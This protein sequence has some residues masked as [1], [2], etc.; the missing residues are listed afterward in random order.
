MRIPNVNVDFEGIKVACVGDSLTYGTTLLNRKVESYP[1]RL[2]KLLGKDYDVLNLGLPGYALNRQS[3]KCIFCSPV[4][5]VLEK[6]SPKYVVALIG[7]NDARLKNYTS[8]KDFENYY[9]AFLTD[10]SQLSSSPQIIA[11]TSPMSYTD[12]SVCEFDFSHEILERLVKIQ[13]SILDEYNI[14][15]IDLYS[16]TQGKTSLFS[17]DMLHFSS[18]GAKFLAF[19]IHSVLTKFENSQN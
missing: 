7:T 3:S 19:K 15:Y 4:F 17:D 13:R 11:M 10:L 2:A 6:Y 12:T 16:S 1:A 8:D 9:R 14:P 18:K 5:N